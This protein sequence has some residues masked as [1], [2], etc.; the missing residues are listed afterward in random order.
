MNKIFLICL[1][2]FVSIIVVIV[3]LYY[4]LYSNKIQGQ[5]YIA[6]AGG[7]IDGYNY[8]NSLES[9]ENSIRQGIEYI[10]LDFAFTSDSVLV[11]THEWEGLDADE[12][13]SFLE[14]ISRKVYGKYTPLTAFMV[15]SILAV[16]PS[17]HLVLD[18][19][20]DFRVIDR[21]FKKYKDRVVVECFSDEDYLKFHENDYFLPMM[22]LSPN[23]KHF[24]YRKLKHL[25]D[26]R[27]PLCR[28]YVMG[29]KAYEDIKD[30]P[31]VS[32]GVFGC[33]NKMQADSLFRTNKN[34]NLVYIDDVN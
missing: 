16:N 1:F 27:Y 8:T 11:C 17:L 15:D 24:I 33:K 9:V 32:V 3:F 29:L 28:F 13:L 7:Q 34:I 20:S 21:Y 18:K 14:F 25:L 26:K 19:I 31:P 23:K 30:F 5:Y 6:H 22:S 12:G 10:E 4:P 2:L